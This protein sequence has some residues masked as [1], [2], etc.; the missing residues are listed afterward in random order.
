MKAVIPAAGLG[1][2]FLP[3]TKAQPK[4]MIPVVDKPAIQY[5]VEE[6]AASGIRD[7]L[8]VT[9]RGK[10]AIEDH[11]DANVE[12]ENHLAREGKSNAL[13]ELADL[14]SRVRIFYARQPSPRGLGDAIA[15]AESFV[16][17]EPFAVLL[18]DDLTSD[19]PCTRVLLD[20]HRRLRGTV[21]ALQEVSAQEIGRYGMAV[22]EEVEPGILRLTDLVEKPSPP[23]VRSNLATIGRYVLAPSIFESLRSTK[24]DKRG[25][26]QLTDAIRALTASEEVFGVRYR[27]IRHDVG[28]VAGWLRA[29]MA[30]ASMRPELRDIVGERRASGVEETSVSHRRVGGRAAVRSRPGAAPGPRRKS[31]KH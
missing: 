15:H 12:L 23:E 20:V 11:F 14:M 5:V 2:R 29:T 30:I 31:R 17:R 16:G 4:E 13:R 10:R 7:I 27:G 18:G 21:V 24:P 19:P 26:V 6:A 8:I 3:Y 28:N 22:G 9:G 25:E 1:T